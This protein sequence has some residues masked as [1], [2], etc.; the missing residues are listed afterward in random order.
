[1]I[2]KER[3]HYNAVVASLNAMKAR[4]ITEGTDFHAAKRAVKEAAKKL[5]AAN[6]KDQGWQKDVKD[7]HGERNVGQED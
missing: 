1:M 4:G 7:R 6:L 5:S 3:A 2:R